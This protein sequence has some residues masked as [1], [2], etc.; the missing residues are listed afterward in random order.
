ME[1]NLHEGEMVF[2]FRNFNADNIPVGSIISYQYNNTL[3]SHRVVRIGTDD[4]GKFYICKGDNNTFEDPSPIRTDRITGVLAFAQPFYLLPLEMLAPFG[5]FCIGITV[6]RWIKR[7]K[8]GE[9]KN[10]VKHV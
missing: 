9:I 8:G 6:L 2:W 1:P 7:S 3:V 4:K 10:E 5:S